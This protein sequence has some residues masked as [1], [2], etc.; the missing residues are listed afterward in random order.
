[1]VR[2]EH[3]PSDF[4]KSIIVSLVKDKSGDMCLSSNFRP[5]TLVPVIS[6][7]FEMFILNCYADHLANDD[8][9]FGFKKSLGCANAIFTLRTTIVY[10]TGHGSSIYTTSLDISKAFDTVNHYKL[11]R[12]YAS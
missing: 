8:L 12:P 6:K 11:V 3:V 10:F 2:H 1:M 5:I 4:S 9:Q 7:V